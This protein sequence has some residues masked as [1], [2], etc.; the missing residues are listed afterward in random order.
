MEIKQPPEYTSMHAERPRPRGAIKYII[1]HYAGV[2]GLTAE[3]LCSRFIRTKEKKST[4]Y[5]V[6]EREVWQVCDTAYA[7][8]HAGIRSGQTYRHPEARNANAIGVDLC[9]RKVDMSRRTDVTDPDWYIPPETLDRGARLIAELCIEY[10]LTS[11]RV[12]RHY[13]VTGKI[14]PAPLCGRVISSVTRRE[15]NDDWSR[16]LRT[17]ERK[18]R[19]LRGRDDDD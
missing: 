14:C 2:P 9:E 3:N 8:W 16:F 17:I 1:V 12:L 6:D 19:L 7:A 15:R 10:G 18:M 13:D 5:T 4:H 11:D